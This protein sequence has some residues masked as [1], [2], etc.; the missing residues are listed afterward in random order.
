MHSRI[1]RSLP[2]ICLLAGLGA[3][4]GDPVTDNIRPERPL[5]EG[6]P[7]N[8][9][10]ADAVVRIAQATASRGDWPMAA[11]LFR[12]AHALEPE[13]FDAAYGLAR[14]LNK[15]GA[16]DEALAVYQAALKLRKDDIDALR[17][18]GNTLILLDRP[19]MA[20]PH[21]ER[22][23]DIR[24]DSRLINGMAVAY[25]LLD[26]YRAAQ[27]CYRV[28]LETAPDNVALRNNLGLSLLLSRDYDAAVQQ[29]RRAIATPGAT[30]RH[31]IN[32]ALA[33]VLAGDSRTAEGV[34][35]FDLSP[36][37]ARDQIA[38]FETIR[39]LGTS[40]D[41]R[42]AIRAHIRGDGEAFME[43]RK[44]ARAERMKPAPKP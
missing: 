3:C 32:L 31:R 11:S 27:A 36:T 4:A 7:F 19:A 17:G 12:R 44:A 38:Y 41:A 39:A 6:E 10:K 16:N 43:R 2:A 33:L 1:W 35:R 20:I 34:A 5:A 40:E 28:G 21:F 24:Q 29:L 15:L 8:A 26:D 9:P 37:A 42:A 18:M 25:D 14:S 22:A 13:N 30:V 23:L